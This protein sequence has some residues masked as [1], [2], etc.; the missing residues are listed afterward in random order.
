MTEPAFQDGQT[1][2]LKTGGPV[3][4]V[5]GTNNY[6]RIVFS[7][8]F[9]GDN[10][11]TAQFP[12]DS[13]EVAAAPPS[14]PPSVSTTPPP[15]QTSP[16][17]DPAGHPI[18]IRLLQEKALP[19]DG[20][21]LY[22][23]GIFRITPSHLI[24]YP[25]SIALL[26]M[27]SFSLYT[28]LIKDNISWSHTFFGY[29]LVLRLKLRNAF[30]AQTLSVNSY[31]RRVKRAYWDS[32]LTEEDNQFLHEQDGIMRKQQGDIVTIL[33]RAIGK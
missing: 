24:S 1:I 31:K 33:S 19:T 20:A 4:T 17:Y 32:T 5:T 23:I 25:T 21:I 26:D 8:W 13:V 27:Q 3:M 14:P 22:D 12:C 28:R 29:E 6:G 2:R 16:D 18:N 9:Q 11:Q 7:S 30:F 10:L 15:R